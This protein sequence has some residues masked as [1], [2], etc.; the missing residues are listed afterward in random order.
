MK[1]SEAYI[2]KLSKKFMVGVPTMKSIYEAINKRDW[3]VFNSQMGDY[4]HPGERV[5]A[6]KKLNS[7]KNCYSPHFQKTI[8]AVEDFMKSDDDYNIHEMDKEIEE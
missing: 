6:E 1:K 2:E 3:D 7:F 4:D 8:N 5:A